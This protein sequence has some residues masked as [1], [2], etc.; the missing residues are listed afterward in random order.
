M[1]DWRPVAIGEGGAAPLKQ[2]VG[3]SARINFSCLSSAQTVGRNRMAEG[4]YVLLR[5]GRA[6]SRRE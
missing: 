3:A 2:G 1:S 4:G 6:K 5:P